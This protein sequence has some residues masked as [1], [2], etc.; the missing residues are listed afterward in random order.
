MPMFRRQMSSARAPDAAAGGDLLF[1]VDVVA[2]ARSCAPLIGTPWSAPA[3][4]LEIPTV[5]SPDCIERM[6]DLSE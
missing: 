2:P 6:R 1:L 4:P 5:L 3:T